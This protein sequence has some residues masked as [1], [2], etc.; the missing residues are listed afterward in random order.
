[1]DNEKHNR[2]VALRFADGLRVDIETDATHF[3]AIANMT[4]RAMRSAAPPI[5]PLYEA[6]TAVIPADRLALPLNGNVAVLPAAIEPVRQPVPVASL[7]AAV[8][9]YGP[10][11]V[12]TAAEETKQ[13][14]ADK[15]RAFFNH[16]G[17]AIEFSDGTPEWLKEHRRTVTDAWAGK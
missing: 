1:M 8:R 7:L 12:G 4:A 13:E 2:V 3:E 10:A 5:L 17:I 16:Y 9:A 11:T 6:A 15:L 14:C